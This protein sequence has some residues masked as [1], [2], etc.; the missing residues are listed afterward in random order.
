MA[1]PRTRND[2]CVT[3]SSLAKFKKSGFP[4]YPSLVPETIRI[5]KL[6]GEE[7]GHQAKGVTGQLSQPPLPYLG[8]LERHAPHDLQERPL[9]QDG[10]NLRFPVMGDR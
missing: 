8:I 2:D 1:P 4:V 5:K 10:G 3:G 9:G 6:W 7:R